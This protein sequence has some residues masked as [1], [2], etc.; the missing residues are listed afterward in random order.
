ML[1]SATEVSVTLGPLDMDHVASHATC[2][3]L[4]SDTSSSKTLLKKFGG[5]SFIR[6]VSRP[7]E[8]RVGKKIQCRR[9]VKRGLCSPVSDGSHLSV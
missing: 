4:G 3:F 2:S 7:P 9:A 6:T 1:T 5:S 8:R